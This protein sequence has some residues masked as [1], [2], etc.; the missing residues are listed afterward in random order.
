MKPLLHRF[1]LVV[2]FS[3]F[4]L[5]L[6][7]PAS[8]TGNG[9]TVEAADFSKDVNSLVVALQDFNAHQHL[10]TYMHGSRL[11]T[12]SQPRMHMTKRSDIP[13]LDSM[14]AYLADSGFA[15]TFIDFVLLRRELLQV[16]INTTIWVIR[17]RLISLPN[18]LSALEDSGLVV[19]TLQLGLEDP[20]I[21]PGL[22]RI[23]REV[24]S[25]TDLS[26]VNLLNKRGDETQGVAA[27]TAS[28]KRSTVFHWDWEKRDN[29]IMT[30]LFTALKDSGLAAAV[31]SHLLTSERLVE[32]NAHFLVSILESHALNL[33]DLV[34]ALKKSRFFWGLAKQ[35]MKNPQ[36][37]KELGSTIV[38]RVAKGL[39]PKSL[40]TDWEALGL[41]G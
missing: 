9:T 27:I 21:M 2:F 7:A 39:I 12:S 40:I 3:F 11:R 5:A 6:T 22:I 25:Q 19:Q 23:T 1:L 14:F 32:A 24:L 17:L 13:I 34:Q 33:A 36:V 30:E 20:D 15:I 28:N 18:L 31:V 4:R 37:V 16:V 38:S 29:P 26:N 8:D 10:P 41:V 35:F